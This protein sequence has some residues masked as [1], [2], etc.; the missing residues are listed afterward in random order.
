M[1]PSDI[2]ERGWC[3]DAAALDANGDKCYP[4]VIEAV[5]FCFAGAISR[6]FHRHELGDEMFMRYLGVAERLIAERY[7]EE[8]APDWDSDISNWNDN[9]K[10][11][12][13][14]VVN[15]ARDVEQ[16]LGL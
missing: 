1:K 6:A 2:L 4:A 12:Q 16:E 5:A 14:E 9:P 7:L 10:R 13:G 8:D 11:T 3:Q 15:L